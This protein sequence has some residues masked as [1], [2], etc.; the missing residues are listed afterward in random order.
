MQINII[1]N[2]NN[3]RIEPNG[4]IWNPGKDLNDLMRAYGDVDPLGDVWVEAGSSAPRVVKMA[5]C[6]ASAYFGSRPVLDVRDHKNESGRT[7]GRIY[8]I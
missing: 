6:D 4:R 2:K 5:V 7:D 3:I 8:K 1:G